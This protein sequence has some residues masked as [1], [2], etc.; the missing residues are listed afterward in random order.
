MKSTP[1]VLEYEPN[2]FDRRELKVWFLYSSSRKK[3]K[4]VFPVDR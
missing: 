2:V 1:N 3:K 4:Q